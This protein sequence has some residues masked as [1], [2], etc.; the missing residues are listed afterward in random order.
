MNYIQE[1]QARGEVVT[2]LLYIDRKARDLHS[3]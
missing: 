2:G 1:H 3:T